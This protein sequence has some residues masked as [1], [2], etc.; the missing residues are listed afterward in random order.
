MIH[1]SESDTD[2]PDNTRLGCIG[3]Q[4][5]RLPDYYPDDC[6]ADWRPDYYANEFRALGATPAMLANTDP[7]LWRDL[8]PE[9]KLYVLMTGQG[10]APDTN[11]RTLS[12]AGVLV[13]G[14]DEPP[15][16]A[17]IYRLDGSDAPVRIY[18]AI[19]GSHKHVALMAIADVPLRQLREQLEACRERCGNLEAILVSDEK[20][21]MKQLKEFHT[22]VEIM[23]F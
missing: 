20:I 11:W 6:P 10:E 18:T 1:D 8:L 22:L 15:V 21:P 4:P 13:D 9:L 19:D 16:D 17:P 5:E 2:I 3:W 14:V 23:G 12:L 7:A